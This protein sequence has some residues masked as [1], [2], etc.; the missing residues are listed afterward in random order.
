MPNNKNFVIDLGMTIFLNEYVGI[1]LI[2]NIETKIKKTSLTFEELDVTRLSKY[3][4][5][6]KPSNLK[7]FFNNRI[8]KGK[9]ASE[10]DIFLNEDNSLK[11]FIAKGKAKDLKILKFIIFENFTKS[12]IV[13][14]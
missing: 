5:V 7:N 13:H 4:L 2:S 11:N 12:L 9:L 10:I 8:K 14:I 6:L 1:V 3:S